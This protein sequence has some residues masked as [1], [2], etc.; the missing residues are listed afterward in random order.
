M[1][2]NYECMRKVLF[3]LEDIMDLDEF[4]DPQPMRIDEI[5]KIPVLS[6]NYSKKDIAYSIYMLADAGLLVNESS[7]LTRTD[8]TPPGAFSKAACVLY[9]TYKGHEFLQKIR[10]ETVWSKIK[11]TLS[12]VG[13]ITI[14]LIAQVAS[15][16]LSNMITNSI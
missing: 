16:I 12:P 10:N 14:D 4:L 7:K 15:N 6:D 3:V 5:V 2:L 8:S 13:T 9:V 1:K 11:E